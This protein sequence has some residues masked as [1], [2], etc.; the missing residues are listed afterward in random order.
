VTK[1]WSHGQSCD[2][3][4]GQSCDL[5]HGQSCDLFDRPDDFYVV[6]CD[7]M[8]VVQTLQTT[9]EYFLSG[10]LKEENRNI[11]LGHP[12]YHTSKPEACCSGR[13]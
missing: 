11:K 7:V 10:I 3:S 9:S 13:S 8:E 2:L 12:M 4:H 6:V 5:S 1:W